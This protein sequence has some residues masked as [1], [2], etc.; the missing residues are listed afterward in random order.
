MRITM[1][2]LN[3]SYEK[4]S[5]KCHETDAKLKFCRGKRQLIQ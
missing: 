2:P 3:F 5:V 1:R 4:S